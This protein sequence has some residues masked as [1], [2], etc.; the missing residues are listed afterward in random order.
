MLWLIRK[1]GNSKTRNEK[2]PHVE[3]EIQEAAC[4]NM[5]AQGY[6]QLIILV[7]ELLKCDP[8]ALKTSHE[9]RL[10]TKAPLPSP[11]DVPLHGIVC[12]EDEIMPIYIDRTKRL[13]NIERD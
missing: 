2:K 3:G 8:D 7:S 4:A 1:P 6:I 12:V 9:I 5:Y 13:R 10:C 11:K